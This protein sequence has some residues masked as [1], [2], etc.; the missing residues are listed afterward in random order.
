[1]LLTTMWTFHI[2]T[3]V[4]CVYCFLSVLA[5]VVGLSAPLDSPSPFALSLSELKTLADYLVVSSE[6]EAETVVAVAVAAVVGIAGAAKGY[7]HAPIAVVPA[8]TTNNAA[9]TLRRSGWISLR[10]ALI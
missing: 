2:A 6:G 4:F 1:M 7:A 8:S 10:I 5:S 9:L 3:F